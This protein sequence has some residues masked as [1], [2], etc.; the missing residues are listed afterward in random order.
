MDSHLRHL[1]IDS[2][3]LSIWAVGP[4]VPLRVLT[5]LNV[6]APDPRSPRSSV[7]VLPNNAF[8]DALKHMAALKA[9]ALYYCLLLRV[10][11]PS[12][13]TCPVYLPRLCLLNFHDRVDRCRQVLDMFDIPLTTPTKKGCFNW[14]K[15]LMQRQ[16]ERKSDILPP[17][18]H[19]ETVLVAI[20]QKLSMARYD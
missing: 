4:G 5:W 14:R 12:Y 7:V 17:W 6:F 13:L 2:P 11:D 9:I 10:F 18:V 20:P 1:T 8:L 19:S 15:S 16:G 3:L